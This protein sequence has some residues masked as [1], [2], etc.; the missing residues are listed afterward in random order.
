MKWLILVA[1]ALVLTTDAC[2]NGSS[3]STTTPTL[4]TT[5]DV[6][7]GTVGALQSSSN[8]F[9]VGQGGGTVT[10][11]LTSAVQT[12]PGGTLLT[13]VTVQ[14]ALGSVTGSTCT[15]TANGSALAQASSS[16]V[17][18]GPVGAGTFCVQVTEVTGV[19]PVAYAVAVNHP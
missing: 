17:L 18:Q 4:T 15:P 11:T 13:S 19:G 3:A 9:N 2:D 8:S 12:L 6:L 16:P 5:T 14:V 7:V 1:V 10:V